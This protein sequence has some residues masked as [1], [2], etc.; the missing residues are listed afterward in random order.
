MYLASLFGE[1]VTRELVSRYFIGTANH[2]PGACVF[3]Q[4]DIQGRIRT[5]K[6]M[7]YN[8][9]TGRRIKEPFNYITWVH[10]ALKLPDFGLKQCLFGEHLLKAEP[11]KPVAIVEAEK[12]AI[13][14]SIYLPEFVWLAVGSLS[15]LSAE[16]CQVLQGRN[17]TLYPDLKG[18]ENWQARVKELEHLGRFQV[19]GLLESK[20][21]ETQRQK[22]FDLA[23]YL[24]QIDYRTIPKP[25]LKQ[26]ELPPPR[27][28]TPFPIIEAIPYSVTERVREWDLSELE[29][30]FESITPPLAPVRLSPAEL[31]TNVS[32]FID[33][34]LATVRC[35]NGKQTFEPYLNRLEN[36]KTYLEKEKN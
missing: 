19:S 8:P 7:L 13:I 17:V 6:I 25:K 24:V 31:I 2:W 1:E 36:L 20:A 12:T 27:K 30:Y 3:W 35:N 14:A 32:L 29:K 34:H 33:S 11:G 23:D 26:A 15:N 18:F 4:I 10:K 21:T 5:G 16:R 28:E 9:S 22:G